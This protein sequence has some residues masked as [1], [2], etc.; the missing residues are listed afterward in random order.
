MLTAQAMLL[1]AGFGQ[2]M[3]PLTRE[4]PKPAIPV[5]G[6]PLVLQSLR[7][8]RTCGVEEVILNLH[9]LPAELRAVVNA[10]PHEFRRLSFSEERSILGTGGGVRKAIAAM[11]GDG[12]VLVCNGDMLTDFD[13]GQA[14]EAHRASKLDATLVLAPPRDGYSI[15]EIDAA[16]RVL[17][18][19]GSPVADP[20]AVAGR[21]LFT[22][23]Q[24]VERHVLERL[25]AAGPSCIVSD[26]YRPLAAEGRLGSVRHDGFWW[27]FGAPATYLDGS[28]S[29]IDACTADRS[30]RTAHDPVRRIDE[31]WVAVGAGAEWDDEARLM[32]RASLGSGACI[33]GNAVI[34]DSIVF[35]E[36]QVAPGCH[37][38]RVIVGPGVELPSGLAAD[39]AMICRDLDPDSATDPGV[40]RDR[41][42]LIFEF[43]PSG[44]R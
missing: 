39:N 27:E 44:E 32:G 21:H 16:G 10:E 33:A 1:T 19:A 34:E 38:R 31:A 6:R 2:R 4:M 30:Q 8:L 5:L 41:G 26:L 12:P 15:V 43:A 29:L 14:L 37:L 25:P 17:S 22:G 40:R 42:L 18:L 11:P 3:L 13:L 20:N 9:H 24:V 7:W 36:S 35:P 23:C 28:L